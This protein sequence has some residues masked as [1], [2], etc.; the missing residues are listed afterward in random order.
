MNFQELCVRA[1]LNALISKQAH[2][3]CLVDGALLLTN[4][5]RYIDHIRYIAKPPEQPTPS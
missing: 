3:V 2:Y 5:P 4:T 1:R